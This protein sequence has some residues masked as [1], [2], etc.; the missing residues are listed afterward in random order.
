M[1]TALLDCG[2]DRDS[3]T[4]LVDTFSAVA[5]DDK[6]L[7]AI[8]TCANALT[9]QPALTESNMAGHLFKKLLPLLQLRQFFPFELVKPMVQ[10]AGLPE[11][12]PMT[13]AP[14]LL[15]RLCNASLL[16]QTSFKVWHG[17]SQLCTV[18]ARLRR[19]PVVWCCLKRPHWALPC[20][21]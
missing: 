17:L 3:W 20:T 7:G 12:P 21:V 1:G 11:I 19:H 10:V 13:A 5:G 4:N 16:C 8:Q 14:A 18:K 15:G 2:N 6:V 9:S